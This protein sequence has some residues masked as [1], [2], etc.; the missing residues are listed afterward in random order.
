[1]LVSNCCTANVEEDQGLQIDSDIQEGI[2]LEC[3]EHC[4]CIEE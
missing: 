3:K 2:C 1:M 4:I